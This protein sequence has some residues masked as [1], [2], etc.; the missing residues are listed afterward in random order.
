MHFSHYGTIIVFVTCLTGN[1]VNGIS[2]KNS[3]KAYNLYYY[4]PT[5]LILYNLFSFSQ[6]R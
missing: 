6:G 3:L 2:D 4:A 1:E 5:Y